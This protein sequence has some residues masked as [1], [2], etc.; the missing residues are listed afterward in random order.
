[1]CDVVIYDMVYSY[2]RIFVGRSRLK[3]L[4]LDFRYIG[5]LPIK[6]HWLLKKELF[7]VSMCEGCAVSNDFANFTETVE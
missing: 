4:I 6:I 1:M 5:R 3:K 7:C 2:H